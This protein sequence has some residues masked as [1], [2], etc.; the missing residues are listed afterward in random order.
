MC[1]LTLECVLACAGVG[2]LACVLVCVGAGSL[3]DM[4]KMLGR[5]DLV[6]TH[7]A[8]FFYEG[9]LPSTSEGV[10]PRGV[11]RAGEARG[12]VE[13]R[14]GEGLGENGPGGEGEGRE[15]GVVEEELF[16]VPESFVQL[17]AAV[18]GVF[19]SFVL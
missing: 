5:F 1:V 3:S 11:G 12:G 14:E 9:R 16:D 4:F 8:F 2:A 10:W 19:L 17:N 6:A 15:E 7:A 18:M 13:F